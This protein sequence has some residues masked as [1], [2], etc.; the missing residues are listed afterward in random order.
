MRERFLFERADLPPNGE[1]SRVSGVGIILSNTRGELAVIQER[2]SSDVTQ[3]EPGQHSFPLET[4]KQHKGKQESLTRTLLGAMGEVVDDDVLQ[5]VMSHFHLTLQAPRIIPV[6]PSLTVGLSFVIFSGDPDYPLMPTA[7]NEV[8][9]AQWTFPERLL[10]GGLPVRSFARQSLEIVVQESLVA[11][12]M[13]TQ[14]IPLFPVGFSMKRFYE[15][16]ERY[17]DIPLNGRRVRRLGKK[18]VFFAQQ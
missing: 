6:T 14:T 7:T 1:I 18:V 17:Q 15:Q 4:A 16:R 11:Q 12:A 3:K 2:K 10:S 8:E 13:T 5:T 9:N